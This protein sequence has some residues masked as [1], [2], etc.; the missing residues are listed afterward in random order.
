L[1]YAKKIGRNSSDWLEKYLIKKNSMMSICWELPLKTVSESNKSEHWTKSSQRH[2]AQ[3]FFIRSLFLSHKEPVS[4]P[5]VVKMTRIAPRPLDEEDNLPM[6]FKWVKDEIGACLFPEKVIGYK[7]KSGAYA[8][9]KG[10]ADSDPRVQWKYSQE[11]GKIYGV[12]IEIT[13][14]KSDL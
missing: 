2:K 10:H 11:K 6:A 7:K 12:R 4:L 9:N 3:Q 5:C 14:I 1:N 8:E 13:E